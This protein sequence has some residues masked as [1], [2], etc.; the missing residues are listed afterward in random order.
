[1]FIDVRFIGSCLLWFMERVSRHVVKETGLFCLP[2][3]TKFL[4]ISEFVRFPSFQEG[5]DML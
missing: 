3:P 1:M 2:L 4:Y 5:R